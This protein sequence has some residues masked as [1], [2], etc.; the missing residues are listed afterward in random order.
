[1][2]REEEWRCRILGG[3][4]VVVSG[5]EGRRY[6]YHYFLSGGSCSYW[7]DWCSSSCCYCSYGICYGDVDA[8]FFERYSLGL[9]SV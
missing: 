8:T 7:L 9:F 1:M 4:V 2:G 3:E 5:K 6:L